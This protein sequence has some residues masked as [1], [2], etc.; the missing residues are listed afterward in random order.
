MTEQDGTLLHNVDSWRTVRH[1]EITA[2]LLKHG[3]YRTCPVRL[4]SL[5]LHGYCMGTFMALIGPYSAFFAGVG[6]CFIAGNFR[7]KTVSEIMLNH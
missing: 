5:S 3:E 4:S 2:L 1:Y 7:K 6:T